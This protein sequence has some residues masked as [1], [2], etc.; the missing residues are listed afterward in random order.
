MYTPKD[1]I[2]LF[3]T[4]AYRGVQTLLSWINQPATPSQHFLNKAFLKRFSLKM[5]F[6]EILAT[7]STQKT[8]LNVLKV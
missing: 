1:N 2:C 8:Q 4:A 3:N 5:H 6:Q 7:P